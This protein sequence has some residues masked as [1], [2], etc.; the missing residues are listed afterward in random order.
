MMVNHGDLGPWNVTA[1]RGKVVGVI[2]WDLARFGDPLDDL[3]QLALEAVSLRPSTEDRPG[4]SPGR[5]RLLGRLRALLTAY[6]DV[7]EDRLLHHVPS[8]LERVAAEIEH[9]GAAGQEPFLR[10]A[11]EGFATAYRAEA[12]HI[13]AFFPS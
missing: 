2:D 10:F 4:A 1:R 13:R 7:T 11:E 5:A 9:R 3:A 6:G 12:Q 8:Y